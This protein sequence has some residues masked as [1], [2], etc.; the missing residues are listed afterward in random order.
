M[1]SLIGSR[2]HGR[3]VAETS[4][5]GRPAIIPSLR[6]RAWIT[7]LHTYLL[8]PEDPWPEGY[9]LPDTWGVTGETTQSGDTVP[10]N[11]STG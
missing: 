4:V 7:G 6:G 11:G 9:V 2:F 8:D 3:I 1:K 5:A 10:S